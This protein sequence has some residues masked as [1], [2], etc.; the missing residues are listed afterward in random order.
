MVKTNRRGA[1]ADATHQTNLAASF[2]RPLQTQPVQPIAIARQALWFPTVA[3]ENQPA[4]LATVFATRVMRGAPAEVKLGSG[5]YGDI[6]R[7]VAGGV[8]LLIGV[9][10]ERHSH[11]HAVV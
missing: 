3:P 2:Q 10:V 8:P 6:R 4:Q 1:V 9:E 5:V 7:T 11:D